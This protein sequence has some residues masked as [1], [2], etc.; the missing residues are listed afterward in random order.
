MNLSVCWGLESHTRRCIWEE[1]EAVDP[2][3]RDE[4]AKNSKETEND[5]GQVGSEALLFIA[6]QCMNEFRQRK[7][8]IA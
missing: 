4:Y 6:A 2:E 3:D 1:S 8:S 7:E 5:Y